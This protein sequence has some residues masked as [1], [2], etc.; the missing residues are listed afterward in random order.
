MSSRLVDALLGRST[1]DNIE[2]PATELNE[3]QLQALGV[4]D[5]QTSSSEPVTPQRTIG[6]VA[7]YYSGVGL[8]AGVVG[9]MPVH[10]LRRLADGARERISRTVV[11]E[12]HPDK[13]GMEIREY[14]V[15]SLLTHGNAYSYK[16]R[17]GRGD[18]VE[19]WPYHPA[20]VRPEVRK[21]WRSD[22]NPSGK[23]FE[24]REGGNVEWLTPH[25]VLHIPGLSYD[26]VEGLSPVQVLRET[27]GTHFAA[28]KYAGKLFKDGALLQGVLET[29][30]KLDPDA[31][32]RIR[33]EWKDQ[34]G[35]LR[36]AHNVAVLS[37][38]AKFNRLMLPPAD[39][40]LLELLGYGV[41]EVATLLGLPPHLLSQ[42]ERST[43]WG[44]GIEQQNLQMLTF[45][46]D[47]KLVRIETRITKECL[48]RNEY[49]KFNR[50]ALLRADTATRYLAYQRARQNGWINGDEIRELEDQDPIPN[51]MG[52]EY[53]RPT[54]YD[55]IDDPN[56]Q[57][58]DPSTEE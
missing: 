28:Q 14:W 4:L 42:V 25:D 19:L 48:G 15:M 32:R 8:L 5:F 1:R 35:G 41:N 58:P 21:E 44:S 50:A 39:A 33:A 27:L 23:R 24:I 55:V 40:Q 47:P 30:Q 3:Q 10:A 31:A 7:A 45:N 54:N 26:G 29:E 57:D 12:P 11:D 51:G 49:V 46:V 18:V 52:A 34:Y 20:A 17:N 2:N 37:H 38:G 16:V 13:T 56:Q 22:L 43:S 9:A 36:N 53:W 6:G